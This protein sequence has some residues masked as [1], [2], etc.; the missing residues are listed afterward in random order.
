MIGAGFAMALGALTGTA[1][2]A[3]ATLATS[4]NAHEIKA[5]RETK[6]EP[7]KIEI[8][9]TGGLDFPP[10]YFPEPGLSPKQYGIRFGHGNKVRKGNKLRLSHNAKLKRRVA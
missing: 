1:Q 6:R 7:K 10:I 2:A 4:Q 9:N 5:V 8:N 3:Q